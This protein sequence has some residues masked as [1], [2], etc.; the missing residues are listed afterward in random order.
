MGSGANHRSMASAL[1]WIWSTQLV[2]ER[3]RGG[4]LVQKKTCSVRNVRT[5]PRHAEYLLSGWMEIGTSLWL[6][7][8]TDILLLQFL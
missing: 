6:A 1:S 8:V 7:F 2:P 4:E 5:V 3:W